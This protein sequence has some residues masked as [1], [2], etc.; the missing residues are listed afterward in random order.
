MWVVVLLA[1]V[2]AATAPAPVQQHP[3]GTACSEVLPQVRELEA[4]YLDELDGR[5]F[6]VVQRWKLVAPVDNQDG[7]DS[8]QSP[9]NDFWICFRPRERKL[10]VRWRPRRPDA[11]ERIILVNEYYSARVVRLA[12][13]GYFLERHTAVSQWQGWY[14]DLYSIGAH[15]SQ[16]AEATLAILAPVVAG[17]PPVTALL[18]GHDRVFSSRCAYTQEGLLRI[19]STPIHE[20][21]SWLVRTGQQWEVTLDPSQ[22]FACIASRV[23]STH[24]SFT[25]EVTATVTYSGHT[26]VQPSRYVV[27][28][29]LRESSES[30]T[31]VVQQLVTESTIASSTLCR[32]PPEAFYLPYYGIDESVIRPLGTL[33]VAVLA[34]ASAAAALL[35]LLALLA[36]RRAW[37]RPNS[38][39]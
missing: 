27:E 38:A 5:E 24:D 6:H 3:D 4:R 26:P 11:K 20:H 14:P 8:V 16:A 9:P 36:L 2:P 19:R 7:Q 31:H 21:Q 29:V 25:S 10:L 18:A 35:A 13:G 15:G 30:S 33:R 34:A 39:T 32:H 1:M 17:G 37:N 28:Q 12:A 23:T 22:R